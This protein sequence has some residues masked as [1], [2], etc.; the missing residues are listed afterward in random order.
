[1]KEGTLFALWN[2]GTAAA[3]RHD[4]AVNLS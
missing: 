4:A 2:T 3:W 1:V